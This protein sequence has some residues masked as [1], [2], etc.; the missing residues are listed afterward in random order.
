[1]F[2]PKQMVQI[3]L[4]PKLELA[5]RSDACSHCVWWKNAYFLSDWSNNGP[6]KRPKK[7]KVHPSFGAKVCVCKKGV[8]LVAFA[9]LCWPNAPT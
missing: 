4:K 5:R 1:M 6:K 2:Q 7:K 8:D 9:G 3:L